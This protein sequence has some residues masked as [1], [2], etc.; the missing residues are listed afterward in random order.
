[1]E[2]EKKQASEKVRVC[3]DDKANARYGS[4]PNVIEFNVPQKFC[5]ISISTLGCNLQSI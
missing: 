1:M 4:V 3:D 2:D 5:T